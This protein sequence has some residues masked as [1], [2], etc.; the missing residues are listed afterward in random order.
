ML[1]LI[2]CHFVEPIL[3]LRLGRVH[4]PGGID[5]TI[6][7]VLKCCLYRRS[8]IMAILGLDVDTVYHAVGAIIG[9]IAA[10]DLCIFT[11]QEIMEVIRLLCGKS[12]SLRCLKLVHLGLLRRSGQIL[13]FPFFFGLNIRKELCFL[14]CKILPFHFIGMLYILYGRSLFLCSH[15]SKGV[16]Q[17]LSIF[18]FL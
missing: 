6:L 10:N 5:I 3:R 11:G 15:Y 12:M 8:C 2:V 16:R 4:L 7:A 18:F 9:V 14:H 13:R 1:V 17:K